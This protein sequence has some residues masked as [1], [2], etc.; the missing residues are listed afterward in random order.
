MERG[1]VLK[2]T[3]EQDQIEFSRSSDA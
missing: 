1:G 2:A 3:L